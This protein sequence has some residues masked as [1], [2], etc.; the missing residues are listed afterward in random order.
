MTCSANAYTVGG[1]ISGLVS[2]GLVL[3]Q[4]G[5]TLNVNANAMS[6]TF[7]TTVPTSG[8]YSVTVQTQPSGY[9][10]SVS[11]G[12]GTM[13]NGAVSNVVV[14]CAANKTIGGSITGLGANSGLVLLNNSGDATTIAANATQFTMNTGMASGVTYAITV[15]SSPTAMTCSV[16]GGSGT[17][18]SSNIS[19]VAVGC[20]PSGPVVSTL[21]S[22]LITPQRRWL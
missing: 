4:G 22:G 11:N 15:Q 9:F 10:C 8:A 18:A 20:A 1:S 14:T 13:G 3:A 19:N 5:S 12:S 16:T 17:V 21:A 6:F 2:S 7:P